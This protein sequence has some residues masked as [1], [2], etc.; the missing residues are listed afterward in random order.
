MT[1]CPRQP[2][3]L[4]LCSSTKGNNQPGVGQQC[5]LRPLQ[6]CGV[7]LCRLQIDAAA[8]AASQARVLELTASTVS[9]EQHAASACLA[10]AMSSA[11]VKYWHPAKP[12]ADSDWGVGRVWGLGTARSLQEYEKMAGICFQKRTLEARALHSNQPTAAFES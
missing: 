9:G 3:T 11:C 12:A 5:I 7:V 2:C 6:T 1:R 8:R 4:H 10:P